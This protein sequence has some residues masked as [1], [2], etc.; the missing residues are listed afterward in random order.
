MEGRSG[1]RRISCGSGSVADRDHQPIGDVDVP[2]LPFGKQLVDGALN[3]GSQGRQLPGCAQVA[4]GIGVNDFHDLAIDGVVTGLDQSSGARAVEFQ[5]QIHLHLIVSL[6]I[7][8]GCD[9][10]RQIEGHTGWHL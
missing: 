3:V 1:S 4:G 9:N 2:D 6:A 8:D 10:R 7:I 5:G